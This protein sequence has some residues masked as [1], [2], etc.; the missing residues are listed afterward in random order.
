MV[1]QEKIRKRRYEENF[2]KADIPHLHL[3]QDKDARRVFRGEKGAEK[4]ASY[5]TRS[6]HK[7]SGSL[8]TGCRL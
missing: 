4:W 1:D 6:R 8:T 5:L 2:A 3:S 7:Y